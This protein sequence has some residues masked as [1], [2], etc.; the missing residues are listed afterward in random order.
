[1]PTIG[2]ECQTDVPNNSN[3]QWLSLG[4]VLK[5]AW[6]LKEEILM[7]MNIKGKDLMLQH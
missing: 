3:I 1:M 5:I 7:F 6:D 4:K 2:N